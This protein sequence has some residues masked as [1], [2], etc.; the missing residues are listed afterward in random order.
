MADSLYLNIWFPTFNE[1]EMMARLLCVVKQFPAS[2]ERPGIGYV[3][4]HS[5]GWDEPLVFQ[6][7]FDFRAEPEH[8]VRLASQFLHSDNAYVFE[9]MWDLWTPDEANYDQWTLKAR[10]VKFIVHGSD[11][12]EGAFQENGHIQVDFG[13]DTPFLYEEMELT[14]PGEERV[15]QNVQK[16][17]NFTQAVEKACAVSGRILWSESEENLAQKLVARLQRVQ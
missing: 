14:A 12:D 7:S 8:A 1:T 13:L 3:G 9:T 2:A 15:K 17:V 5:V 11:F 10:P 16:L 4:V 6:E